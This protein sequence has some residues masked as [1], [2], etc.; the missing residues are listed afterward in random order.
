M[1]VSK[2]RESLSLTENHQIRGEL[3]LSDLQYTSRKSAAS[4]SSN[5]YV[6]WEP[7]LDSA[8]ITIHWPVVIPDNKVAVSWEVLG[9]VFLV[10]DLITIPYRICFDSPAEDIWKAFEDITTIFFLI[11][12]S[13]Q[14]FLA[15]QLKS[16]WVREPRKIIKKYLKSMFLFDAMASFPW[17]WV[18][19]SGSQG[20]RLIRV[21]RFAR[22][23]RL[24]RVMKLNKVFQRLEE[25]AELFYWGAFC[26]G[27]MRMLL[28]MVLLC[29]FSACLWF[30]VGA[31]G[32]PESCQKTP[33]NCDIENGQY[34]SWLIDINWQDPAWRGGH[35]KLLMYTHSVYWAMTTMT[36]VGYGD[37]H[38]L[39]KTEKIFGVFMLLLAIMAF[40]AC[41]GQVT[42]LVAKTQA[43][44]VVYKQ[45]M[46]E[47]ARYMRWRRLPYSLQMR[48]RRYLQ[49]RWEQESDLLQKEN[50]ILR[51]IS[52]SLRKA[53]RSHLQEEHVRGAPFFV[54]FIDHPAACEWLLERLSNAFRA[55]GD[56]LFSRHQSDASIH[57]VTQGLLAVLDRDCLWGRIPDVGTVF[58]Q[59]SIYIPDGVTP[60]QIHKKLIE[61]DGLE[62]A[63]V[64]VFFSESTYEQFV[65]FTA[66]ATRIRIVRAPVYVGASNV[67]LLNQLPR[68]KALDLFSLGTHLRNT[69]HR[70]FSNQNFST[71]A[72]VVKTAITLHSL[73]PL[74][75]KRTSTAI[76]LE[77]CQELMLPAKEIANLL[78]N[79]PFLWDAY[80]D[81]LETHE[82]E[83]SPPEAKED[84]V[85]GTVSN[86]SA[87]PQRLVESVVKVV[88]DRPASG[89]V[90]KQVTEEHAKANIEPEEGKDQTAAA[91]IACAEQNREALAALKSEMQSNLQLLRIDVQ[92]QMADAA[93][94]LSSA[95]AEAAGDV[96]AHDNEVVEDSTGA[97][98]RR[99]SVEDSTG[100]TSHTYSPHSIPCAVEGPVTEAPHHSRNLRESISSSDD[101][102]KEF[103]AVMRNELQQICKA[104]LSV[105]L[106]RETVQVDDNMKSLQQGLQ[107]AREQIQGLIQQATSRGGPPASAKTKHRKPRPASNVTRSQVGNQ[108]RARE[109]IAFRDCQG[110]R[111]RAF[112]DHDRPP[113]A[114]GDWQ[115]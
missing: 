25:L 39:S 65:I 57:I 1:G 72:G 91:E 55:P 44:T 49:Y 97:C 54:W 73:R 34:W 30:L 95:L 70:S 110:C 23:T 16:N 12:L 84:T 36:T 45:K 35:P 50:G 60:D 63:I 11:D 7:L 87:A 102:R 21:L 103:R 27:L 112:M 51:Q 109:F 115:V 88:S 98:V 46:L 111:Q 107:E 67:M 113:G 100:S 5:R 53:I 105:A 38:P 93:A 79:F 92:N 77:N 64:D 90:F 3:T 85:S 61:E 114:H 75:S 47:L 8:F 59:H 40:S 22:L 52:P 89:G 32:L 28:T 29:H 68:T 78:H 82:S 19:G 14:F 56:I 101:L 66:K 106:P 17:T 4:E 31:S 20:T 41:C 96:Q 76:A 10:F 43:S 18:V 33:W 15:Y 71:L 42:G 69:N 58:P 62:E 13:L 81:W 104:E 99:P 80:D 9:L 2:R 24:A 74:A 86:F 83:K 37:L 108:R 48:V 6:V 26:V 94:N